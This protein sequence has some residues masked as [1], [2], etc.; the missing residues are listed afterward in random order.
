MLDKVRQ[1]PRIRWESPL[2]APLNKIVFVLV[3]S[4]GGF[5]YTEAAWKNEFGEW[6]NVSHY[7]KV[8]GWIKMPPNC[9]KKKKIT[10]MK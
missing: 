2:D 6:V 1:F 7:N 8:I 10:N 5:H 4:E 9:L 3:R